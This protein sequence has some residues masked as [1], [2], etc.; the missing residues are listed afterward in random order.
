MCPGFK[1][2]GWGKNERQ[3]RKYFSRSL[4]KFPSV[5]QE[6][7]S[8][9]ASH[10]FEKYRVVFSRIF[11]IIFGIGLLFVG[12]KW[13]SRV[14]LAIFFA[15]ACILAAVAA[16]G[17]LWCALYISGYKDNVLI[18]LGP[19]SMCRNPLYF[20]SL[21]GAI[22]VGLATG[23]VLVPVVISALFAVYYPSV[24]KS[25]EARLARIH[26]GDFD[27]YRE[28]TRA[29]FPKLNDFKEP[30]EYVVKPIIFRKNMMD[31][32]WFILLVAL[33][34]F[35]SALHQS[36]VLPAFFSVY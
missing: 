5:V 13:E 2:P 27:L 33:L 11:L 14:V 4:N 6:E 23:T 20:F 28:R 17:R 15:S 31:A 22:G 12:S 21:A 1:I 25:E 16:L 19:Y 7:W 36:G 24:I 30:D 18:T 9:S 26:Q 34:S 35:T 29:F 3:G 10:P 8:M 32:I